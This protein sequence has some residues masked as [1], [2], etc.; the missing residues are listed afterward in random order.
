VLS[1]ETAGSIGLAVHELATNATKYGALSVPSGSVSL[2]WECHPVE[3]GQYVSIVWSESGGP[4]TKPPLTEGYGSRVIRAAAEPER[5]NR[6]EF[7]YRPT[8]LVC[9]IRF[10][11]MAAAQQSS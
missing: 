8:G 4:P 6:V 11:K 3:D 1:S 7:E 9:R 5:D 2:L 10:T